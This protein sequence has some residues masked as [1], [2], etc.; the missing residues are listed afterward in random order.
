MALEARPS[1]VTYW[2]ASNTKPS[3]RT[4]SF[5]REILDTLK[6]LAFSHAVNRDLEENRIIR[7]CIDFNVNR[8]KTYRKFLQKFL[9]RC[10]ENLRSFKE[11]EGIW[12]WS[13]SY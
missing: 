12:L 4:I 7:R 9:Q 10:L 6:S 11:L 13:S 2:V 3:E 8:L 1:G 5:L